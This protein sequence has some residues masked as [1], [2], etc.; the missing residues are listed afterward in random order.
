[1]NS[2]P[3]QGSGPNGARPRPDFERIA[4][5][6]QG[7][8]ALGSYQAGAYQALAEANLHP[9][10]VA[11]ISIGSINAA[12]IAGNAPE[13]RVEKLRAF[14][15]TIT[16]PPMGIPYFAGLDIKNDM[17][18]QMINQW[19]SMGTLLFGAPSFFKPRVPPPIFTPAG[20]PGN[21]SFYDIAPLKALLE[22]LVDFDRIN[23]RETRFSVGATNV[24]TGNFTYFD[25][26]THKV[27]AAHVMASGSLPPGF[28]ATEIDGE[29]YWDGGIVSNT[30]LQWVLDARP[31]GDTLAFQIDLWSASGELPRDMIEVD[32]RQKDIR[33][34][35]RTR[36]GTDQFRKMQAVRRAAA[37]LLA[38]MR[39]EL[40][41]TPEAELLAQEADTKV[42]NI[43]HLIYH[44]R[45]Y[46][47]ASKD[48]EFSRRTME[49]HWKTGYDDMIRTLH[50]PEV[51]QR[52]QSA[53]GVFTF[54]LAKQGRE[55]IKR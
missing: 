1:M 27:G 34:S 21:L 11:G 28:P 6:L 42:Y 10:W 41:Q 29:F 49:E 46:E 51:L 40:R 48:Y 20:N 25:N 24:R 19:R 52:P 47:G 8:G 33:Y 26:T 55:E 22:S 54:D 9:D 30:P 44:A 36:A 39:A 32:V 18:H 13:R 5:L 2:M 7:G 16:Q 23:S 37:M 15:E 38:N 53:D 31:R 50:H 4:L 17:Q 35:S 45:K 43:I 3:A 12:L 14:W